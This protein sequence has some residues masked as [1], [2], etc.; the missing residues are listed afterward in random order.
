M[1]KA[2]GIPGGLFLL[3]SLRGYKLNRRP[4]ESQDRYHRI[5]W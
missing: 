4:G 2:A 3:R 5:M 1:Q